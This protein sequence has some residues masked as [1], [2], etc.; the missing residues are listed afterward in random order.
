MSL[1]EP[2]IEPRDYADLLNSLLQNIPG[3]VPNWMPQDGSSAKA[4]MRIFARYME[5]YA[6]G[7]NQLPGRSLMTFLDM[8]GMHLLLAQ[9]ARAPLVFTL[10]DNASSDVTLQAGCRVAAVAAPSAPRPGA[11]T[12]PPAE[13]VFS[14]LQTQTLV[15]AKLKTLYSINPGSDEF[16]D[17][18]KSLTSGFAFF[19]DLHPT[20][21]TIYLGNN[22]FFNLTGDNI[23]VSLNIS[24]ESFASRPLSTQW[25]YLSDNGWSP[26]ES[27]PEADNTRGLTRDGMITIWRTKGPNARQ[28]V[29]AGQKSYWLRGRLAS[30]L[31]PEGVDG[32]RSVP[33]V[34]D[35]RARVGFSRSGIA[36]EAAF[37]DDVP[38]DI[39]KDFYPFGSQ[40]AAFS[41]FTL[42]TREVFSRKGANAKIEITLSRKGVTQGHGENPFKLVWEYLS[43]AGWKVITVLLSSGAE[44]NF[45]SDP[46]VPVSLSLEC[47]RDWAEAKVNGK[48]SYWLRARI[49]S[50]NYGHALN[51]TDPFANP[52]VWEPA[53]FEPPVISKISISFTYLSG[54]VLLDYCYSNN[55][56][57][58]EDH[59]ADSRWLDRS[60][61]PF[62]PVDDQQPAVHFG[63]D[64]ALPEGLVSLFMDVPDEPASAPSRSPFTWEYR[65]T[66]GWTELGVLDETLGFQQSGMIQFIGQQDAVAA[67]GLGGDLFWVRARLKQ[68]E[69]MPVLPVAGVWL[70]AAWAE[71]RLAPAAEEL[72]SSDGNPGQTFNVQRTP[73]IHETKLEV[74]EWTGRGEGWR[75]SLQ[76]FPESDLRFERDPAGSQITAVWVTWS[77]QPHLYL[78]KPGQRH[79]TLERATG[80]LRLGDIPPAGSRIVLTYSSGGGVYGNV[81]AGAIKELRMIVPYVGSVSN[82]IAASGGAEVETIEVVKQRGPQRLRHHDQ[83]V[84]VEDY[85]WLARQASPDVARVRCQPV[86]G[87]DGQAQR[88]WITLVVAPASLDPQPLPS[89][90]FGRRVREYMAARVPA[91]IARQVRV[92]GPG[93]TPV[94]VWAVVAPRNPGEAAQVE[95]NLREA[96]NAFLH[97]LSGGPDGRGW[98]FGQAVHLSQVARL[99]ENCAGVDYASDVRLAVGEQVF[100]DFVPINAYALPAAGKHEIKMV[101]GVH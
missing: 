20:G 33:Q 78:S 11:K 17:H 3:Y 35:I 9:A 89:S 73:I 49:V 42:G 41:V 98:E 86:T 61:R 93:Y 25:E 16:A 15:R 45:N 68:G 96:L 57:R 52:P 36:P 26:L 44:Y 31:L 7:L 88:G 24:L 18:S 63:F 76:G 81:P 84:S 97:P 91:S 72:G 39:S 94:S 71:E 23:V 82:P 1:P 53:N 10:M 29:V 101:I 58:F 60:F 74:Q 100:A 32:L 40:P 48:K 14:T 46:K 64:R 12:S 65:S 8:L 69:S 21:H 99:I 19:D 55:D 80:L 85:E 47:P 50:G 37:L 59:T 51:I 83:A 66:Q 67:P 28:D 30:P 27:T 79:Y 90:G 75:S 70:N 87:P 62:V 34:N 5:I 4:L 77:E 13:A 56:F 54:A 38:L 2:I 22:E 95:A 43:E 6:D 92:V